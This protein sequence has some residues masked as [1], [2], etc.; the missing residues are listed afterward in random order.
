MKKRAPLQEIQDFQGWIV[1]AIPANRNNYR[2]GSVLRGFNVGSGYHRE[3]CCVVCI[4]PASEEEYLSQLA[5]FGTH[6]PGPKLLPP[7]WVYDKF[8]AE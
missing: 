6:C 2:P 1:I 5:R 4:G 8:I 3:E 7:H